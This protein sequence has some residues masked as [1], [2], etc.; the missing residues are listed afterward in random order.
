MHLLG[1]L[2][3]LIMKELNTGT[4]VGKHFTE[5]YYSKTSVSG[6]LLAGPEFFLS[7]YSNENLTKWDTQ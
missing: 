7:Y 1:I 3:F 4:R 2:M 6:T 5:S